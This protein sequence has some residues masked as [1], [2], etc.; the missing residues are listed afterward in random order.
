[1]GFPDVCAVVIVA[2]PSGL[3]GRVLE[4]LVSRFSQHAL[5]LGLVQLA[6]GV[7]ER[8]SLALRSSSQVAVAVDGVK[9]FRDRVLVVVAVQAEFLFGTVGMVDVLRGRGQS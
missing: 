7:C 6:F 1:M 3:D 4:D 9:V 8:H 2:R 5:R